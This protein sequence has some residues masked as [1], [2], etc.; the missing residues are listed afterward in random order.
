MEHAILPADLFAGLRIWH[1]E[2]LRRNIL[3]AVFGANSIEYKHK[4][5]KTAEQIL[6]SSDFVRF[7]KIASAV[8]KSNIIGSVGRHA[9]FL[10]YQK[11]ERSLTTLLATM[12]SKSELLIFVKTVQSE[13]EQ[14]QR[15]TACC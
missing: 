3:A 15:D 14:Q 9:L 11:F 13:I 10:D 7:H 8:E 2:P 12:L 4:K 6:A 1:F 5:R